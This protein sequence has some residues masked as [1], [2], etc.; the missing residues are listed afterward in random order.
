[1]NE[2]VP[3][4]A[5]V[6]KKEWLKYYDTLPEGCI[7]F[8]FIDP[9]IGQRAHNDYT[10]IVVVYVDYDGNYYLHLANRYRLTP[11]QIVNKVFEIKEV[12][13]CEAIGIESVAYQ[14]ALIYLT[15]EE[16]GKRDKIVPLKD[17]RRSSVSKETRILALVPRFEWNKLYIRRGL[18]DFEDEYA[19]FPRASHDDI[20][21][22]LATIEEIA[23]KPE[24]KKD[25][26]Q[27]P[28]SPHDPSYEKYIIQQ[29]EH[30]A[31]EER[32]QYE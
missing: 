23:R 7:S 28:H 32:E 26:L 18:T 1:M 4:D 29:L 21:D 12:F 6:F 22:A 24:K 25:T 15:S 17:I 8:A 31:N 19:H 3:A 16:M 10:A 2:V 27:Q 30:K 11:S 14:E 13:K 20:M 9:A 5:Q